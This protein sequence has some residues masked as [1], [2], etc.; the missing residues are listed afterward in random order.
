MATFTNLSRSKV[1]WKGTDPD[2][3]ST[4]AYELNI[5]DGLKL[6]IGDGFNLTISPAGATISWEEVLKSRNHQWPAPQAV[7]VDKLLDIGDGY[8]LNIGSGYNLVIG[9]QRGDTPW[10]PITRN[11]V[12][13]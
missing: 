2:P 3:I 1:R 13:Y 4:E 8:S 5:G 6:N 9:P 10:T 7:S 12:R 11:K